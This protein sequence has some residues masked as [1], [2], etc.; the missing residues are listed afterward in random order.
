MIVD[1]FKVL[2]AGTF[3]TVLLASCGGGQEI[4]ETDPNVDTLNTTKET[5][6]LSVGGRLFGIPSPVQA[7]MAIK[8]AGLQYRSDLGTP[9]NKLDSATGKVAQAT[10]LGAYGAD[11]AYATVNGDG[12]RAMATLVAIEKLSSKLDLSNAF[13]KNLMD[14]FRN[15]LNNEDSLLR[16]SGKAFGAAD[17]YLKTNDREDVSTLVLAGGWV[18]SL[19][20]LL[21]DP[22]TLNDQKI[23]DRIGDQKGTLDGLIDL[24]TDSEMDQM[25][26]PLML[27]MK[28]LRTEFDNI[29]RTYH[30]ESP[31]TDAAKKVTYIN[32]RTT[33]QM[34]ADKMEVIRQKVDAVRNLMIP[35]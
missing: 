32:S 34:P 25:A 33:V 14:Q 28:E 29:T 12:Q 16:F 3:L 5:Q 2:F 27:A 8:Q 17:R 6:I 35:A 21:S 4:G 10:L 18:E 13:D 20:L 19:H 24:L 22:K 31:V 11:L 1:P 30:Y 15:N 9:L 7:A 23:I 26:E